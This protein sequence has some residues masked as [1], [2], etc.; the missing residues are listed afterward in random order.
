MRNRPLYEK[1]AQHPNIRKLSLEEL[2]NLDGSMLKS[3]LALTAMEESEFDNISL[4]V[5][6]ALVA[7]FER[8]VRQSKVDLIVDKI[9]LV[10]YVNAEGT[11][12]RDGTITIWPEG[13]PVVQ[14]EL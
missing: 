11:F 7:D 1:I 6:E 13:R 3:M 12:N 14:E 2:R 5:K 4:G 9:Q 10:G 8:R